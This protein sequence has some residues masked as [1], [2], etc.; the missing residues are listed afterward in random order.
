[1]TKDT[2]TDQRFAALEQENRELKAR[3]DALE[4]KQTAPRPQP[5]PVEEGVRVSYPR[6]TPIV[7]PTVAE[8][9]KL[10][11][12][13]ARAHPNVV[14]KFERA[15]DHHEFFKGFTHS[16]ERISSLRRPL[17][18]GGVPVL[19]TKIDARS[20]AEE[21]HRWL[22]ER[23]TPAETMNGSFFCAVI[24]AGDVAY[25]FANRGTGISAFVGLSYGEGLTASTAAWQR[26]IERNQP[27]SLTAPP[28][29]LRAPPSPSQ[30]RIV[31]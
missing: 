26:V 8:F 28:A 30:V 10:L 17:G 12:I 20:W 1:M 5:A 21:C 14:P 2:D 18:E 23:G 29:P 16:F 13:V 6:S 11:T 3:L 27:R 31:G 9:E 25:S 19:N 7:M 22:A 15:S 4:P 24:A